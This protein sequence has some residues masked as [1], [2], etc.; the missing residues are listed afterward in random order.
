MPGYQVDLKEFRTYPCDFCDHK[1]KNQ[2]ELKCHITEAH[3][4]VLTKLARILPNLNSDSIK[5]LEETP[6]S[7]WILTPEEITQLGIDWNIYFEIF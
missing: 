2:D 6:T 5:L 7:D 3:R 4:E 1:A